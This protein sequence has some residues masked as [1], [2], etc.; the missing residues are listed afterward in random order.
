MIN[1]QQIKD[2]I[3]KVND[4]DLTVIHRI[5]QALAKSPSIEFSRRPEQEPD[6]IKL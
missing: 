6:W 4:D 2:E 3:D 1:K 5:I